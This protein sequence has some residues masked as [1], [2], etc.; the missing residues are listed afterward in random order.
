[1]RERRYFVGMLFLEVPAQA[2]LLGELTVAE[3]ALKL[4]I[5]LAF[6]FDMTRQ[7]PR[8]L[9]PPPANALP[10][11]VGVAD[12]AAD[13]LAMATQGVSVRQ[14]LAAIRA[15]VHLAAL[16]SPDGILRYRRDRRRRYRYRYRHR[17]RH[18]GYRHLQRKKAGVE[19][20]RCRMIGGGEVDRD[21]RRHR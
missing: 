10:P 18:R 19:V 15:H 14:T 5:H 17:H 6:E 21:H 7:A 2:A 8:G 3:D 12:L 9:V 11:A 4:G 20:D 16:R 1:M 13:G